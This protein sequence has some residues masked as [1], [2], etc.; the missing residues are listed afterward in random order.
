MLGIIIVLVLMV[1]GGLIAFLGDKIGTKVEKKRLTMFGLRPKYTSIIVTIISGTLI[2]FFTV[3][4]MAVVNENIR[5]ALFGLNK[6]KGEMNELNREIADKNKQLDEG[7][8]LLARRTD[9]YNKMN[10]RAIGMSKELDQ[11][12]S[13]RASMEN[14]LSSVQ[15]AY[16]K[17]QTDVNV[18][19]AEIDK[20]EKTRNELN[21][22]IK[23][24][25][26]E[27]ASLMNNIASIREG[28]M[29][30]RTGQVVGTG[31]IGAGL[32]R[33]QASA[34][35][36]ALLNHVS[37]D[38]RTRMNV[39]DKNA[40]VMR[41]SQNT[42][43]EAASELVNS[44]SD[45]VVRI[46]SAG[47]IMVGEPVVVDF[48]IYDNRKIFNSGAVI[49]SA[50]LSSYDKGA[51]NQGR[52]LMF[53]HDVNRLARDKGV[54]F[55]PLTGNIGQLNAQELTDVIRQANEYG[56]N[57]ILTAVAKGDIYTE[58]PLV[59]DVHVEKVEE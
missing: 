28:T 29:V 12:E 46:V 48:A 59:I 15:K 57:C 36:D 4:V 31:I 42:F 47:N 19:A 45:K 18:S 20:L 22:N 39:K 56:G 43:E 3:A 53:L 23:K 5:V 54:L 38:L 11:V 55:D 21:G 40:T 1:M 6:L 9:E 13:Q 24:L 27:R 32:S 51:N 50:P 33:T 14:R 17:A 7:K 58:G 2:S 41:V 37:T 49:L 35:L 44:K 52:I 8:M 25:N 10:E 34:A 30:Y 16:D 26:H